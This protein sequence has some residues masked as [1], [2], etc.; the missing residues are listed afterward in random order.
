MRRRLKFAAWLAV[1]YSGALGTTTAVVLLVGAGLPSE[2]H[3]ALGPLLAAGA[4]TLGYVAGLVRPVCGAIVAWLF[5][6][7]V[8]AAH[9]LAEQTQVVLGAN[10]GHR[11]DASGA[12]ELAGL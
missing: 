11:V 9:A 2:P 8:T 1:L 6:R 4:P 7:Y 12:P 10:P 5:R 3:A